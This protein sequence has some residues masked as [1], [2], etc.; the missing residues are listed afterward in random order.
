MSAATKYDLSSSAYHANPH[1]VFAAMRADGPVARAHIPVL[2]KTWLAVTHEASAAMLKNEALFVRETVNAGLGEGAEFRWWMPGFFR[3]LTRNMLSLDD[4]DH[5]RLRGLVDQAFQRRGIEEMRPRIAEIADALLDDMARG[6]RAD[7]MAD[8]ARDLPLTVICELLGLPEADR[9]QLKRWMGGLTRMSG[10]VSLFGAMPGMYRLVRYLKA[11]FKHV[12]ANPRGGLISG[13]IEAEHDGARLTEDELLSMV[14]LLF[15]AGH[16]TTVH[17][18]SG[19]VLALL[20]H[21]EQRRALVADWSR[22]PLAVEECL[23][24]VTP[25][26]MTKPR[27]ARE[28]TA[29]AG[30]SIARGES[31]MALLAAANADP[32]KFDEPERFDISRKPNPHLAFSTGVHFCLGFQLA[33][34]EAQVAF[35]RLFTR[36]PEL[37]LGVA[38]NEIQWRHRFGLRALAALPVSLRDA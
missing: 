5:R 32:A 34:A 36:F 26:Q 3:P 2:G 35:E 10:I 24:Y 29:L 12:R 28:A 27:Y 23:R 8:Y 18:I 11:H 4:P 19:G 21:P 6:E 33:R 15:I 16:E 25:V 7:I 9:P 22:L 14:F 13:L 38:D 20:R 30:V 37:S 1:G 17:L 31:V